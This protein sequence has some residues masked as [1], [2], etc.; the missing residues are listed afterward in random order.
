MPSKD[1][2]PLTRAM[3]PPANET[4]QQRDIRLA[5]EREAK[6]I[7]DEIDEELKRS[8]K[9]GPKP[10]KILL[11]GGPYRMLSCSSHAKP[12]LWPHQDRVNQVIFCPL[13]RHKLESNVMG[14]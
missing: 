11:L 10:V 8:A 4:D 13:S 3:A 1:I 6:K 7:S 5:K 2:D 14:L 12:Y 9:K